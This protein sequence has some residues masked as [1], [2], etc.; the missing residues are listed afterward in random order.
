MTVVIGIFSLNLMPVGLELGVELTRNAHAS[1]AI[2][3]GVY[4]MLKYS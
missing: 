4:V 2:L 1:A 3:W